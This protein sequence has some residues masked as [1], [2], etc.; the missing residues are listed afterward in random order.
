ML[1]AIGDIHGRLDLLEKLYSLILDDIKKV[2]DPLGA[3]II[4]LGDYIDR[5]PESK[6]VLDFLVHLRDSLEIKHICLLGN[7]EDFLLIVFKAFDTDVDMHQAYNVYRSWKENGGDATLK[8]FGIYEGFNYLRGSPLLR[9]YINW[10][11]ALPFF[12][13]IYDY[14]FCHSGSVK[15]GI[16]LQLETQRERLLWTRPGQGD[17][18]GQT[19]MIIH[20]HTQTYGQPELDINRINVDT[21]AVYTNKLTAAV[22]P[23]GK[24][25]SGDARF[26]Q[27]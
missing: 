6:Q 19:K 13:T 5:G 27:T 16:P 2:N 3:Q 11:A 18:I 1:Y 15:L 14:I 12:Y 22:L 24:C 26:I 4:F 20:G 21:A 17:Y 8:S 25:G 23:H 7:H 9:P 10:F